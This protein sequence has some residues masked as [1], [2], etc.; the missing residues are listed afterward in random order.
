MYLRNG[1]DGVFVVFEKSTPEVLALGVDGFGAVLETS[2]SRVV[3]V[4]GS[5]GVVTD[6]FGAAIVAGGLGV[7]AVTDGPG[8]AAVTDGPGAAVV[9]DGPG[10]AAV[11]AAVAGGFGAAVVTGGSEVVVVVTG[12][13]GTAGVTGGSGAVVIT[14]G[15]GVLG[16]VAWGLGPLLRRGGSIDLFLSTSADAIS[17]LSPRSTS[18]MSNSCDPC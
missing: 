8:R 9:T 7:A 4:I 3:G 16:V 6:D 14:G 18:A 1:F 13:S 5:L 11:A 10:A 15:P 12:G 2:G 17:T